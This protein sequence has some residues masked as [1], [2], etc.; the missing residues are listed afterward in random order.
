M[1]EVRQRHVPVVAGVL[2]FQGHTD[3]EVTMSPILTVRQQVHVL[4]S[5]AGVPPS[6]AELDTA[7]QAGIDAT[8]A[9]LLVPE[10]T[11]D[12]ALDALLA[13]LDS[14][15]KPKDKSD[16][17]PLA[18][19]FYLQLAYS[20]HPLLYKMAL[21]L[22]GHLVVSAQKV[23]SYHR[24]KSWQ[25]LLT[26]HALDDFRDLLKQLGRSAAMMVFL[27]LDGNTAAA[28]NQN[29][30]REFWELF[31]LGHG[32]YTQA[33]IEQ[34]ARCFTGRYLPDDQTD[35]PVFS[36][37]DHDNTPKGIFG[38]TANYDDFGVVDLTLDA[39]GD[40]VGHYLARKLFWF[41]GVSNPDDHSVAAASQAFRQSNFSLRELAHAILSSQAFYTS[42]GTHVK[43]PVELFAGVIR[44][45]GI[46][47]DA[48]FVP[49]VSLN[50]N[51]DLFDYPNVSGVV[52][53]RRSSAWIN[54]TTLVNRINTLHF[55]IVDNDNTTTFDPHAWIH[56]HGIDSAEHLVDTA[57]ELLTNG[58]VSPQQRAVI[59]GYLLNGKDE[60]PTVTLTNGQTQLGDSRVR[61]T[62]ALIAAMPQGQLS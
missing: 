23:D 54:T 49:N 1:L 25:N 33:D 58:Q 29:Y 47:T 13:S 40:V 14:S 60:T 44:A 18:R 6:Q 26:S 42:A 11:D 28:P 4:L 53:D 24:L 45:L 7:E 34:S 48:S 55:L 57:I 61:E 20:T 52:G 35:T 41:F 32:N 36:R 3:V 17:S 16:Y 30:A 51:Q 43:S 31:T 27:D 22:H 56:K 9:R 46:K 37:D 2:L 39:K 12:R 62:L 38:Q 15:L 10:S 8:L 59:L 19:T 21:F 5:R 50:V